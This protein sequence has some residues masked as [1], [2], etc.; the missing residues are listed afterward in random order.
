M[1]NSLNTQFVDYEISYKLACL[2]LF[3]RN[4][5][6]FFAVN[7]RTDYDNYLSA[8]PVG[9]KCLQLEGQTVGA[10]GLC[11]VKAGIGEMNWIL[12]EP[13]SQGIGLGK[14]MMN[15][16]ANDA[17]LLELNTIRIA[18]SHLSAPFFAKFGAKVVSKIDNGWGIGM[19]REDM[20]WEL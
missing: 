13:E 14:L 3:D 16:V 7:E 20:I 2:N 1:K 6:R 19:H 11:E 8:K 12:L 10:V 18:A 5:P 9:Y 15:F 4:C 17:K